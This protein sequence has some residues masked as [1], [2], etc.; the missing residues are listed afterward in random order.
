MKAGIDY[1]GITTG[2]YCNDGKGNFLLHKRSKKCRDEQGMWDPGG[3]Q[4]EV[5]QTLEENVLREVRE[6]YGCAGRIL[7]Q[8]PPMTI[9]R[10][11]N[12][13]K[14]HW[15]GIPFFILVDPKKVRNNDPEKIDVLGW[16]ALD[17][18]PQPL[19]SGFQ[20]AFNKHKKVFEKYCTAIK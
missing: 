15:L 20:Q 14:T 7:K 13:I 4:L 17:N 18:F 19:H 10:T 1:V 6:E 12:G 16:F 3:G 2:F 11:L 8:L 5:G 9:F